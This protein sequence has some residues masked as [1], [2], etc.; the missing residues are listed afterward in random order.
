MKFLAGIFFTM[1]TISL[2]LIQSVFY[3]QSTNFPKLIFFITTIIC[4]II[5]LILITT[6]DKWEKKK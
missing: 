2:I 4:A 6:K 1:Y 5:S 3:T